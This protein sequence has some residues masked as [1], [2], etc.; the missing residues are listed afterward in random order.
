MVLSPSTPECIYKAFHSTITSS[1]THT[2]YENDSL[3]S[4]LSDAFGFARVFRCRLI[5]LRTHHPFVNCCAKRQSQKSELAVYYSDADSGSSSKLRF[6]NDECPF[7][8]TT[9]I[10]GAV[11][12]VRCVVARGTSV[13]YAAGSLRPEAAAIRGGVLRRAGV[14]SCSRAAAARE[15]VATVDHVMINSQG[16]RCRRHRPSRHSLFKPGA[17]TTI[18][19]I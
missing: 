9:C 1:P 3:R 18:E 4:D 17:A 13:P 2:G 5:L 7:C 14:L 8:F 10:G 16:C 6:S 12:H 19:R 11:R 15:A